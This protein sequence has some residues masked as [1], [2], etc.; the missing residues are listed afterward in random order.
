MSTNK[1]EIFHFVYNGIEYDATDYAD[2]HPGGLPFLSNM[3]EVS[4]DF[5]EYFRFDFFNLEPYIQTQHRK[6]SSLFLLYL[7]DS[8]L[9]PH[10]NTWRSLRSWKC[11]MSPY[12][13]SKS[14]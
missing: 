3:K 14:C 12:G 10:K 4:K 9:S 5:S 13:A 11:L 6:Y 1:K 8:P 7:W 2:K